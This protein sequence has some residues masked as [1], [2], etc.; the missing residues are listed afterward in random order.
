MYHAV[1]S[2]GEHRKAIADGD[3]R[4]IIDRVRTPASSAAA[5]QASAPL[6]AVGYGHGV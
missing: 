3:L 6:E 1:I 5:P 4:R 2:L